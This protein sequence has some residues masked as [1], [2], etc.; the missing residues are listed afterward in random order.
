M[1]NQQTYQ[2]QK[3]NVITAGTM[4]IEVFLFHQKS[5]HRIGHLKSFST[6]PKSH[7]SEGV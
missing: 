1:T 7:N 6:H 5:H 4:L 2:R 3:H